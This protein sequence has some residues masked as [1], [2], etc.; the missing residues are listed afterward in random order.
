MPREQDGPIAIENV[1]AGSPADRAGL[2]A[3]D[4]IV[5][6]DSLALH[7]VAPLHIYLKDRSGAPATLSV[8]RD[9]RPLTFTLNPQYIASAPA[10]AQYQ[11]GFLPRA[12]PVDVVKLSLGQA[13]VE[14]FKDNRDDAMMT[15][16][17]S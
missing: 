13:M 11:I 3:G 10:F 9:G 4:Q 5:S 17:V 6:I 1:S 7:S 8:L 12:L 16:R 14:S 15:F 2:K